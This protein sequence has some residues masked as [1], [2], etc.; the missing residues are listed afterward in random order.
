M[1]NFN[2]RDA[3][4]INDIVSKCHDQARKAGWWE[5]DREIGTLLMLCVSEL[6]EAMEGARKNLQDDHLPHRKMLEVELA[7]AAI[8]IF[9]IAGF[10]GF[11]LGGAIQDKL[12]YNRARSDHKVENRLKEGGKGF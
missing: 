10:Y 11:D 6:A 9:D 2:S 1:Q 8:R 5:K 3:G 12:A 4:S 7:D